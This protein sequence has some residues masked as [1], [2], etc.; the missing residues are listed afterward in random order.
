MAETK[1]PATPPQA[2]PQ[3]KPAE[4]EAERTKRQHEE[5]VARQK[6][7]KEQ[8]KSHKA[9]PK[10][11]SLAYSPGART[12]ERVP[13]GDVRGDTFLSDDEISSLAGDIQAGEVG[14][15]KLDEEGTPTGEVL[16]EMPLDPDGS[17]ARVIGSPQRKY[18]EIVTPSG[19]PVTRFMNPEPTLWD[20]G[21]LAR[22]PITPEMLEN[23]YKT[24]LGAPVVNQPVAV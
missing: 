11:G 23:K 9:G 10:T 24:P 13:A 1:P 8:D 12:G 19:A 14:F 20:A 22:N 3:T 17:Y 18:D 6:R 7:L 15:V 5:E 16:R 2:N 4:S 21:M